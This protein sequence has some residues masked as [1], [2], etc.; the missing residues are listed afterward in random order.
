MMVDIS[1][2]NDMILIFCNY[3]TSSHWSI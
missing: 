1:G 2:Y 3:N